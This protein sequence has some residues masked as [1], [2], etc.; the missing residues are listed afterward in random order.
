M[1]ALVVSPSFL[2]AEPLRKR[3]PAFDEHGRALSDFMVLFPGLVKKPR[4]YVQA[5]I[6]HIQTVFANYGHAVV[7]AELNLKLNL[8][9]VS[10]RPIP[11]VRFQI[12]EALRAAIPETR[13]VSHI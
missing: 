10:V 6:E 9:W 8:L 7:F 2:P 12:A 1:S 13:L 3:A 11:G 4:H 5:A